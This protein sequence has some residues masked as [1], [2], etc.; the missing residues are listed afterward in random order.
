MTKDKKKKKPKKIE[1]E[2][3]EEEEEEYHLDFAK[4]R[5]KDMIKIKRLFERIQE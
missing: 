1:R 2:E 3:K 5:Q 4:L